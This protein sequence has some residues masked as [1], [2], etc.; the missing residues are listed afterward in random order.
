MT[1]HAG[2]LAFRDDLAV[3][4]VECRSRG[5]ERCRFLMGGAD[6]LGRLYEGLREGDSVDAALSRVG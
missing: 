3:L 4:E 5:D 2:A 1:M 6:A